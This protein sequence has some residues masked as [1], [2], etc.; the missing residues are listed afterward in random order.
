REFCQKVQN[1]HA[2]VVSSCTAALHLALLINNV[3]PGDEVILPSLTFA[4]TGHTVVHCGAI[5]VFGEVRENTYCLDPSHVETLVTSRTKAIVAVHYAG[6]PADLTALR[7]MAK[8]KGLALIED[9]AH[10][11]GA[12]R[13][14]RQIGDSGSTACFSF[15]T[16]KNITTAEG[17]ML[18]LPNEE[19]LARA[20]RLS[21][22][23][24]DR[25]AWKRFADGKKWRYSIEEFGFKY[26]ANDL[27]AALG[28]AQL[29]RLDEMHR[30]R[31]QV[32]DWYTSRLKGDSR[33]HLPP[34]EGVIDHARH[35]YVL[36]LR[37]G[38]EID[39]D[40]LVDSLRDQ[41]IGATVHYDPLHLHPAYRQRFRT[42]DGLLPL[43]ERIAGRI[44]S[45]PLHPKMSETDVERVVLA[46]GDSG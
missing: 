40:Q 21:L 33:F 25:D 16:N 39:R 34:E 44:L 27:L 6:H 7:E 19:Q 32:W 37:E 11:L 43:T 17:G 22:H 5:P 42:G 31:H 26:N 2:L 38:V 10:A 41:R 30:K 4:S 24:L 8:S 45:L 35:L 36:R 15:Y 28:R 1:S 14:G 23:G 20:E 9:A 12:S 29:S 13:E 46:L 18:T 3:G